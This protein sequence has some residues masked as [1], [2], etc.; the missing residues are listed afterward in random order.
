MEPP[1]LPETFPLATVPLEEAVARQFRLLEA[2]AAHFEGEQLLT[3]DTGVVPGPGRPR[4]TA[5]VEAV[6]ADFFGAEDA[7][8]VQGAGTG[9]I[10]AALTAAVRPGEELLIHRAP[11]Y[12]TTAVTLRG[13][14]V[15]TVE[16]D[17]NDLGALRTA[18]AS[19]RFRW[20]VIQ[21][22]RQRLG[23]SYDPGEVITVCRAAGVR[24]VVDDNY[25]VLRTPAAGVE[26][27][28]DASCFSLFKLHGPEG[29]GAVVGAG[30]LIARVR[31]DNYS[32]GG[33]VQ[34]HQ[35]LDAL[36]ALTHVPVMWAVQSRVGAEV[37]GRL[38]AGEVD[39]VAEVRIA[40]AQDRCLLVRLDRPVAARL[41]AAA[42][43]FGAAPYPV[44][45][46]S[47]YE[48]APLFYRMSSSSLDD[49]PELADWTVRINPMRAGADLVIDILR[50][51][52]AALNEPKG[53]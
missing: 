4:T 1:V 40:N 24:T 5:R 2:T 23:D 15:R 18:L 29:V 46:N 16:V 19:G 27:G 6:L 14:G 11:V 52:L 49:A 45:S 31:H 44:G 32:G 41:P 25:A 12:R 37:A 48:I 38:A 50:R 8:L 42:A 22:S 30:E 39:G 35:A 26:L 7:A 36:R 47:R 34:G 43:E 17:L 10:R 53:R 33:Q 9:A 13:L 51:S 3:A 28:A 21:H 20:A